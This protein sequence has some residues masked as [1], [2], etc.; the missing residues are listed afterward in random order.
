MPPLRFYSTPA[1]WTERRVALRG[2]RLRVLGVDDNRDG[3]DALAAYLSLHDIECHAVYGAR[4]AVTVGAT[5][6]PHIVLMDISMPEYDGYE[7][8]RALRHAPHTAQ[9]FIVAHTALDESEVRRKVAGDEF[10]GYL[11]KGRVLRPRNTAIRPRP[12]STPT[13][14]SRRVASGW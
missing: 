3:A 1:P 7:A 12:C 9:T 5:W 14:A 11:Q 4:D 13:R 6:L 8:A 10:D 2:V